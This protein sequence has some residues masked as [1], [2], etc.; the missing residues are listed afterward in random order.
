MALRGAGAVPS[1]RSELRALGPP[2]P[3][4][5]GLAAALISAALG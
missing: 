3:L 1:P 4:H 2:G 5:C